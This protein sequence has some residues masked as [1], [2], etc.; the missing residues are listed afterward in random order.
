MA[1]V[2]PVNLRC[3]PVHE[4]FGPVYEA[5]ILRGEKSDGLR[6]LR[7]VAK[8]AHRDYAGELLKSVSL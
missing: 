2:L 3:A 7:G 6:H 5:R 1:V 4:E 8:T